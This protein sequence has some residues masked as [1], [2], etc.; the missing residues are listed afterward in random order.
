MDEV[1]AGS[2]FEK[3]ILPLRDDEYLDGD[4]LPR[5]KSCHTLRVY[6]SDDKTFCARCL[7]KCQSDQI[8]KEKELEA[9]RRNLEEFYDRQRLSLMGDRYKDC[10]L[11]TAVIT[12]HNRAAYARAKRYVEYAADMRRENIG[13]YFYGDNSSGKTYITACICNE[14]LRKGYRCVY[15]NF[16]R[17]LSEIRSGY[18]GDGIG[19]LEIMRKLM[20]CDF[21]FLDD[22]GKEFIG[23]VLPYSPFKPK[24]RCIAN[25]SC[26]LTAVERR[27]VENVLIRAGAGE[28]ILLESPLAAAEFLGLDHAVI[29]DIGAG[30]TEVAVTSP[31]GIISGCSVNIG[32]DAF[33]QA[34]MDYVTD[35]FRQKIKF[36]TAEKIKKSILSFSPA[37]N[38][39]CVVESRSIQADSASSLKLESRGIR[40]AV[41][42]LVDKIAE[43]VVAV[44]SQ[45]PAN[46]YEDVAASGMHLCGGSA[47]IP[48]IDRYLAD[49]LEWEAYVINEPDNACV[50]GAAHFFDNPGKLGRLLNLQNLR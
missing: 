27:D 30:K 12:K 9:I 7:C 42:P 48:A 4:G 15:T 1:K 35:V 23:R 39:S 32:G 29:V 40:Q 8:E 50:I 33:N 44:C 43:T 31:S 2:L 28:V 6:V 13:L 17:I 47:N 46:I 20:T 10:R 24:V 3:V 49:K 34:I 22:F 36:S 18:S 41:A 14:L 45:M 25:I 37:D 11:S 26:G 5:C 16:A 21:A 38:A 19:E